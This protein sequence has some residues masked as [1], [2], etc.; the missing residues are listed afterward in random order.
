MLQNAWRQVFITAFSGIQGYA[1]K[2]HAGSR[3]VNE[4]V[5]EENA[6]SHTDSLRPRRVRDK[7]CTAHN[8]YDGTHRADPPREGQSEDNT[9]PQDPGIFLEFAFNGHS[10]SC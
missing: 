4:Q 9:A 6:N 10:N 5:G 2:H 8:I 3:D 1:P 7:L